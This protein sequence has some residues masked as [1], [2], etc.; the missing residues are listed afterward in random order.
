LQFYFEVTEFEKPEEISEKPEDGVYINGLY[1]DGARWDR[2][3]H[4][5]EE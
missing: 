4:N 5:L 1:L 3:N 2:N